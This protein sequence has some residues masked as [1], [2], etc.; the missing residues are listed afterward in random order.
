MV[1]SLGEGEGEEAG[2]KCWTLP[3]CLP[4]PAPSNDHKLSARLWLALRPPA[5]KKPPQRGEVGLLQGVHLGLQRLAVTALDLERRPHNDGQTLAVGHGPQV[6]GEGAATVEKREADAQ[7]CLQPP[8]QLPHGRRH[9]VGPG[10]ELVLA[11]TEGR[12]QHGAAA[13]GRAEKV[14][15]RAERKYALAGEVVQELFPPTNVH[16]NGM[17]GLQRP[18]QR[19]AVRGDPTH[20]REELPDQGQPHAHDH[21]RQA[22]LQ[23]RELLAPAQDVRAEG[24]GRAAT[25]DPVRVVTYEVGP[26]GVPSARGI[27]LEECCREVGRT[28]PKE[29]VPPQCRPGRHGRAV[30]AEEL[31]VQRVEQEEGPGPPDADGAPHVEGKDQEREVRYSGAGQGLHAAGRGHLQRGELRAQHVPVWRCRRRLLRGRG[32]TGPLPRL[33]RGQQAQDQ[34]GVRAKQQGHHGL[35][36]P[37][38]QRLAALGQELEESAHEVLPHAVQVRLPQ[39]PEHRQAH[40]GVGVHS[41]AREGHLDVARRAERAQQPLGLRALQPREAALREEPA[42]PAVPQAVDEELVHKRPGGGQ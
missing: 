22:H 33:L 12:H 23:A 4:A 3:R 7:S 20:A 39:L 32:G 15:A 29:P 41:P 24:Q 17:A 42:E 14:P 31:G 2:G 38:S 10:E 25:A 11:K 34:R 36:L 18:R 5:L 35:A 16:S 26:G 1:R 13:Q 6:V 21:S 40:R 8:L 27:R 9:L 37:P 19:G 30:P 28:A